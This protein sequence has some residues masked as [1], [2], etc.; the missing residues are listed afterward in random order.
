MGDSM[1]LPKISVPGLTVDRQAQGANHP[2]SADPGL[3]ALDGDYN[4]ITDT[5]SLR[6]DKLGRLLGDLATRRLQIGEQPLPAL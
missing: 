2:M 4:L 6:R 1:T 3:D 5:V